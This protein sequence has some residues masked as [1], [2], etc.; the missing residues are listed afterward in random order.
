VTAGMG[1]DTE[2]RLDR[3]RGGGS[4]RPHNA[5]TIAAL[6]T[7]PGCARRAIMDA[8]GID[9]ARLAAH[10]G[11]PSQFGQSQ[12][13]LARGNAFE[14]QVKADGC[15][16]L[17]T[18]LRERLGLTLPEVAYT[19]LNEVGGNDEPG[20]R[21]RQTQRLL[22]RTDDPGTLFDHPLLRL[23]VGGRQVYLEPDLIAFQWKGQYHVIEIKSFPVIDGQ[24]DADKVAAAA[25]QSAVYVYAMREMLAT[26]GVS[27]T[28]V[29]DNVILV[30]PKDFSNQPVATFV[31]VRK[32]LTVL[33]R[34]LSRLTRIDELLELLPENLSLSLDR[35]P[36]EVIFDLG[37]IEAR[38]MPE[39]LETCELARFCRDEAKGS[40]YVM[41]RAVC[42][43]LGGIQT[44][45][46][47]LA[48]A[49]GEQDPAPDQAE[50]ATLIRQAWAI[51]AE[52]LRSVA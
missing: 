15:A 52:C 31:D 7:N 49:R 45:E 34:Q 23:P 5:R 9:K 39:C 10:V 41:G 48:L 13:A 12:F 19:D 20:L 27:P 46:G 36:E 32:Q 2:A 44:V 17:L 1:E 51:R 8:A 16:E 25:I 30:C 11:F 37:C 21:H 3:I 18:L 50:A 26:A 35:D 33:R 6:T 42:E 14:A 4:A 40:T 24:A 43:D 29:S 28:V 38:Y 47:V 22:T